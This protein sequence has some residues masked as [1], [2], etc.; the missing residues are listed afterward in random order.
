MA[1]SPANRTSMSPNPRGERH[2][3]VGVEV[4]PRGRRTGVLEG[5]RLDGRPL[6]VGQVGRAH[7]GDAG[8]RA[9]R[10]AA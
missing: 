9:F 10:R 5:R 1:S 3:L 4:L 2:L 7:A 8:R 6:G